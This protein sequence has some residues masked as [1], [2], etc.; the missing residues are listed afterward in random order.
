LQ[1]ILGGDGAAVESEEA[2]MST[3]PPTLPNTRRLPWAF[4]MAALAIATVGLMLAWF[5]V[6]GIPLSAFALLLGLVGLIVHWPRGGV[7]LRWALAGTAL[8]AVALAINVAIAYAPHGYKQEPN[9][10][11]EWEPPPGRPYV[12][13]PEP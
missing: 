5:P 2:I 4:G 1:K 6:L 13:P 12:A 3:L 9:V 10:P 7:L 11:R 8:A